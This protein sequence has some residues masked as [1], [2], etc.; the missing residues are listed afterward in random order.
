M[1]EKQKDIKESKYE[2]GS[3]SEELSEGE[4][5]QAAGWSGIAQMKLVGLE[6]AAT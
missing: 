4:M 3:E 1:V 6:R 5:E 2:I